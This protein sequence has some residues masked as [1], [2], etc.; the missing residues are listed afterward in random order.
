MEKVALLAKQKKVLAKQLGR[1]VDEVEVKLE[2]IRISPR[3]M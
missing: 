3:K 1:K 2:I